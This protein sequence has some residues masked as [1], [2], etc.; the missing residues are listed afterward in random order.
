LFFKISDNFFGKKSES[1][2]GIINLQFKKI[3]KRIL[4]FLKSDGSFFFIGTWDV[5]ERHEKYISRA[6]SSKENFSEFFSKVF[7]RIMKKLRKNL[8][9]SN[10]SFEYFFSLNFFLFSF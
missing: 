9:D 2:L 7:E 4:G 1:G 3:Q 8:N 6:S 5:M 10:Y